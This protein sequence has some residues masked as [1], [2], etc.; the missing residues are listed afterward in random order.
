MLRPDKAEGAEMRAR[1]AESGLT[2]QQYLLGIYRAYSGSQRP[3]NKP[4]PAKEADSENYTVRIPKRA[5]D[6]A[7]QA[8]GVTAQQLLREIVGSVLG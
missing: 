6:E 7:A 2:L 1:A 4:K 8:A 5:V 3:E